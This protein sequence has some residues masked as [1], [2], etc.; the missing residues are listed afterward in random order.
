MDRI[1]ASN[2]FTKLSTASNEAPLQEGFPQGKKANHP[3]YPRKFQMNKI[4]ATLIASLLAAGAFAQTPAKPAAAASAAA[5]APAKAA[6]PAAPAAAAAPAVAAAPAKMEEK[7]D[8]KADAAKMK[9]E[10]AAAKKAKAEE[11][12]AAKK[13]KAE[14]KK[15]AKK[16]AKK[17]EAAP[18]A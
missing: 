11:M 6:A 14:E 13:A 3:I 18:K 15:A 9:E 10:K 17:D 16:P 7:K 4:L 1:L 8:A 2:I 12:K 5:A